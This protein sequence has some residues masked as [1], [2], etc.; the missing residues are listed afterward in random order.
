MRAIKRIRYGEKELAML[1][2]VVE[3]LNEGCP[4]VEKTAK[5]VK[6]DKDQDGEWSAMFTDY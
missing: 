2:T 6:T 4:E 5:I 3:K 1:K